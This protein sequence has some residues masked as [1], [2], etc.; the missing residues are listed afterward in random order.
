[1]SELLDY[2]PD[3][4]GYTLEAYLAAKPLMHNEVR[5][6]YRPL[7]L[8]ERATML[9]ILDRGDEKVSAKAF[10]AV[11]AS[12]ISKWTITQKLADGT[13]I[14]MVIAEKEVSRLKPLLWRRLVNI[15][16]LGVEAGDQD[17]DK[18][19]KDES[20]EIQVELDSIL[21]KTRV[22]DERIE[23]DRKN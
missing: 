16:I 23:A 4:D 8:P 22:A 12:R 9:N 21:N 13:R 20:A 19:E 5:F 10:S 18:V 6:T 14:P 17:P 15:V 3:D 7:E 1:M 11:L 2:I